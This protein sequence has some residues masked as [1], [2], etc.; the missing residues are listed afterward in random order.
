MRRLTAATGI[1]SALAAA[2][3][4]SDPCGAAP[5]AAATAINH[6]HRCLST[7][8]ALAATGLALAPV[9]PGGGTS[10]AQYQCGECGKTFRLLN[11]LNHHIMTK[12]S[13]QAK[14]MV[15]RDGKLE[16]IGTAAL[17]SGAA[18]APQPAPS[19]PA[20]SPHGAFPG[21]FAAPIGGVTAA[22]PFAQ[23]PLAQ[24]AA[25]A[26]VHQQ[27]QQQPAEAAE[28]A[29]DS[30]QF[31]C[32]ICQKTFRLEAALQHHYLAKHNMEMPAAGAG[33]G[34]GAT[35][36]FSGGADGGLA[37][38]PPG[39][40]TV[41]PGGSDMSFGAFAAAAAAA[42]AAGGDG[43]EG[44][45]TGPAAHR[46]PASA[47]QFARQQEGALPQA[48]QYHLDVAPNA[49]EEGDVAAHW[50][51]VNNFVL[52]GAV[53]DIQEGYVFE[54]NVLQFTLV[55]DF[56]GPSPGDPDKDFHTVRVYDEAFWRPLREGLREGDV[57]L[58][59]GRLRMVPQYD[60][61]MKKYYHFPVMQLFPGTG[62][63]VRV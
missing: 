22:A 45:A 52:M 27:Q 46:S 47:I 30:R 15:S 57:C 28:E 34:V 39:G 25:A 17:A 20:A 53:Q 6:P 60:P 32:T 42:A 26:S 55:T 5:P 44:S 14:A 49:P 13:G 21:M 35:T 31:V 1:A 10:A 33:A 4:R 29:A 7:T 9:R 2:A 50:R 36:A 23:A 40:A 43:G 59:S 8:S 37:S 51:C 54:D 62:N 61:A 18:P 48:P 63:M 56:D 16:E 38:T 41:G 24:P 58:V 11:A 19:A 3:P 12:H